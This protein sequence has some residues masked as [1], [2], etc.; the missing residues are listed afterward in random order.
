MASRTLRI[1]GLAA[2]LGVALFA[3]N[4]MN[5]A[6]VECSARVGQEVKPQLPEIKHLVP[7]LIEDESAPLR[8]RME[9]Y[10]KLLQHRIVAALQAEEPSGKFLVDQWLRKEGGEGISC[11]LQDGETFEKAGCNIS[12]VHGKLPLAAIKQ[13]SSGKIADRVDYRME[14]P[15][16]E[17]D[18][19]PFVA[20][21]LSL[22]VHPV[23]PFAPTVHCNY[24]YFE[25]GHPKTLK[26][27]SPNPRYVEAKEG[28]P[29]AP[30]AAWWFGGGTDLTPMYLFEDDAKHFHATLKAAAD[31]QDTSL[32]PTWKSW[33]DEYFWIPHRNEARGIGGVFFDDLTIPD[34]WNKPSSEF[35][36]KTFIPLASAPKDKTPRSTNEQH[37]VESLFKV[38][39]SMGNSFLPSYLP[40]LQARKNTPFTQEHKEWQAIRR[41]RYVEF[42]LVHD[43]GTKFGLFTPGARIESILMSLPLH[44]RWEYMNSVNGTGR[45]QIGNDRGGS[46][47][48][49]EESK[50][51]D[52]LEHPKEWV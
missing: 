32:F 52:V 48:Q 15:D 10:I 4:S 45:G 28:E 11:V 17:V 24:R 20:L 2:S 37:N 18:H 19:L 44:A 23:N 9:T 43:R 50:I 38:V 47:Q 33:C 1:A 34:T 49:D 13:M 5:Q 39:Q 6:P 22:V 29:S 7:S 31:S 40:I 46:K 36:K 26:D 14:G 27:G 51:Q 12:V 30:P 3:L 41:G 42:N 16:P 35:T 8:M 21:G 25:V